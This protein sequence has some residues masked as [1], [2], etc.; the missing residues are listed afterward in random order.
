MEP[1]ALIL[2]EGDKVLYLRPSLIALLNLRSCCIIQYKA[3]FFLTIFN[4]ILPYLSRP[5][6]PE[7]PVAALA[8][9][10]LS[11]LCQAFPSEAAPAVL[12]PEFLSLAAEVLGGEQGFSHA[13]VQAPLLQVRRANRCLLAL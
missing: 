4:R 1:L 10:C 13:S 9:Q 6:Y 7:L 11:G 8:A 3:R 2:T 5:R 12:S